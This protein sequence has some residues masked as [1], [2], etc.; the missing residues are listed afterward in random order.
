MDI[1]FTS[2]AVVA[3]T[4]FVAPLGIGLVPKLRLPNVVVEIILGIV[5]GPSVLGW[6]KADEPVQIMS[7]I[8]LS[9]LLL[10]AGL[11]VDYERLHGR[12][13]E[14]TGLG[15]VLSVAIGLVIGLGLDAAGLVRSPLLIAIMFSATGLGIVIAVLKD[16]DQVETS[17]GQLVIAGSSIAEVGT[18]VLL[19]LF[20]SGESS[21]VGAKVV[22]L[23]LF[24]LLCV[25]ILKFVDRDQAM[26]PPQYRHKLE[27]AGFGV[28]I[29]FFFVTSGIRYDAG[30]L[31]GHPSTLA[32]VPLFLA[33][34]LAVRGLP[35]LLYRPLV[36]GPET[37]AGALLQATSV[38]FFVVATQIGQDMGLISAANSAALIAAGLLSVI[39]FPLVALTILRRAGEEARE[40]PATAA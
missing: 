4:G 35:A 9:F 30:A 11:E 13:L 34:L 12:L 14:V 26:T 27:A 33:I 28:F 10:I 25:A 24:G 18:I 36:G 16:A 6:A 40:Q 22:L 21:S 1:S 15:F 31:F 39:L 32:R 17:F 8:G 38:G 19:T 3:A 7:L 29:P 37:A 5:I 23:G 20:F 2:L